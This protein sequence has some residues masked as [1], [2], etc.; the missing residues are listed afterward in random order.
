MIDMSILF[1]HWDMFLQGFGNTLKASLLAL[2]GSFLLGTLMAVF[3][4]APVRPLNWLGT[5][6]VEFIRNIPLIL[7]VFVFF[8]GLPAIGIRLESFVAGTLGLTVYTA[9]FIAE[10]IRAGILAVS[11]GQTEAAR[12]SGLTYV[13]TMRYVVLPQAIKIVIPPMGNQFINLVKNSSVL[14]VIAG[15]DLMYFGDLISADTF[16][17]FDVY[18]FVA[19]FYLILTLPLSLLVGYLERRL[20]RAR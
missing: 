3:R 10:T 2:I 20:A 16:V 8:V 5:A 13:Q 17:T 9:A 14:G 18:I 12:S 6:Y 11:K 19:V 7:V 4:I 1:D 15:L